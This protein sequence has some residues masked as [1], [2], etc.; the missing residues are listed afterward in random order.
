RFAALCPAAF[1][2]SLG[3]AP[4]YLLGVTLAAVI[5]IPQLSPASAFVVAAT[6]MLNGG[7][8]DRRAVTA[9]HAP[10]GIKATVRMESAAIIALGAPVAAL[11][12]GF[13]AAPGAGGAA[14]KP[15]FDASFEI[16][17]G[18]SVGGAMGLLAARS[19]HQ[20]AGASPFVW[21]LAAGAAAFAFAAFAGFNAVVAAGAAGLIWSEDARASTRA[22]L[23]LR[24]RIEYYVQPAAYFLF[25]ATFAPRLFGADLL[26]LVF[27]ALS[28]TVLRAGPRL[29][30]LQQA[31]LAPESRRFLAWFGGAP[32]AASALFL[33]SLLD[34]ATIAEHESVLTVSALAIVAGVAAARLTSRPLANKFL[35]EMATARKR[36]LLAG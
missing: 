19:A 11:A 25:A 9:T 21:A 22:R 15:L 18:F 24:R 1:R 12:V 10:L 36:R 35:R 27:A 20:T 29:V 17:A 30:A 16:F 33:L 8:F 34:E 4:L 32:G 5:L 28:V 3:G 13:A 7:A 23:K 2:L 31:A 6:L 26:S 14:L